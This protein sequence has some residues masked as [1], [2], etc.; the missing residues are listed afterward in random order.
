VKIPDGEPSARVTSIEPMPSRSM[1]ARVS[2]I[3]VGSAQVTGARCTI[4]PSVRSSGWRWFAL[5]AMSLCRFPSAC[6]NRCA[7]RRVQKSWNTGLLS[8]T[9]RKSCAVS[10]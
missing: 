10:S 5:S 3:G 6:C 8:I 7:M 1:T 4:C 2:R 9:S